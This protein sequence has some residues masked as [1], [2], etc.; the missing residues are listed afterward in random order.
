MDAKLYELKV[1]LRHIQPPI[2]RIIR[3]R[4]D[5]TLEELHSILQAAMGWS[6]SHLHEFS[7]G[8]KCYSAWDAEADSECDD[9]QR[10]RLDEVVKRRGGKILYEYDFGDSWVHEIVVERVLP[11]SERDLPTPVVISGRRSCP[12]EDCGGV[13]G[14]YQLLEALGDPDHPDHETFREWCGEGFDPDRFDVARAN[15]RLRRLR[16]GA[17]SRR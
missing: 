16:I 2:W 7:V 12:P 4:G 5:T 17:R 15:T 1:T 6:D 14:Y 9:E 11:A 8:R 10:V 13:P 3:V